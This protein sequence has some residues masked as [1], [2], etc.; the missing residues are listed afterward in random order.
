MNFFNAETQKVDI[1]PCVAIP[2]S[3]LD[4]RLALMLDALTP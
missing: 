2:D 3:P 4:F 1:L